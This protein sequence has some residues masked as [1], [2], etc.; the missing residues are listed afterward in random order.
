MKTFKKIILYIVL[1]FSFLC[2]CSNKSLNVDEKQVNL[3]NKYNQ[4]YQFHNAMK[5]LELYCWEKEDNVWEC[6]LLPGTNRLKSVDEIISLQENLPCPI[7][8]M[9]IILQSYSSED[10]KNVGIIIVSNPP[11]EEEI[12]RSLGNEEKLLYLYLA[13]GLNEKLDL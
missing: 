9:N 11:K 13:L 2:G 4:Y 6:G 12:S 10:R 5:G 8:Y 7:S 3:N 1:S